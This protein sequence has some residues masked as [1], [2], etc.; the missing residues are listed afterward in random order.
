MKIRMARLEERLP[1]NL[2]VK[3]SV[4]RDFVVEYAENLSVGGLF[5]RGANDLERGQPV[6]VEIA[7]P[8]FGTFKV[9][10]EVAH[11]L[12][13]ETAEKYS[14]KAGA[15]FAITNT[16]PGFDEA[17]RSY[18]LR[19]GQRRDHVVLVGEAHLAK[20]I[21]AAGYRVR[22]LPTSNDLLDT[23]AQSEEPVIGVVVPYD[24]EQEY[25]RKALGMGAP[26]MVYATDNGEDM[27]ELL[28]WLD[29]ELFGA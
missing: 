19:L 1:V 26:E 8:G 23:I 9:T 16:P 6:N 17:L 10:A 24:L 2:S 7:L 28:S 12:P 14:R 11:V 18:L 4:A 21:E 5:V 27:D 20:L 22:P 15:G 3:Y 29:N 13:P 25:V